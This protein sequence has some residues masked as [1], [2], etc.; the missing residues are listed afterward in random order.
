MWLGQDANVGFG[1]LH[2]NGFGNL[3]TEVGVW[4][5]FRAKG[6]ND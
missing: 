1:G 5:L 2:F 4:P 3:G 6:A